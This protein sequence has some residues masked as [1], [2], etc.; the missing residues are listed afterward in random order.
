[1]IEGIM[2][3]G[4]EMTAMAVRHT[5]GEIVMESWQTAGKN[6]AK[7]WKVPIFRGVYAFVD[8][9]F[10]GYKTLMRSAEL[11]GLEEEEDKP[12]EK[13]AEEV[14]AIESSAAAPTADA[15]ETVSAEALTA[16]PDGTENDFTETVAPEIGR[17]HV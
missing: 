2:M 8:S 17:A 1:M 6:R 5:S 15:D 13:P 12:K 3:R 4:P 14:S 11:S 16:E 7:L 10:Y 9:M